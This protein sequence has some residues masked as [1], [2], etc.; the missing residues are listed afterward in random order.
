MPGPAELVIDQKPTSTEL[1]KEIDWITDFR[2]ANYGQSIISIVTSN[3]VGQNMPVKC[4][5]LTKAFIQLSA[6]EECVE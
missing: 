3:L 1:Y 5:L 4:R 2:P 6:V